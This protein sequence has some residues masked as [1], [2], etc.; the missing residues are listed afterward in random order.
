LENLEE[1]SLH[2]LNIE[3]IEV[4]GNCCK[5]LKILYLQNNLIPRI[6]NLKKLKELQYLNLALN[7]IKL[8]EGLDSCES[9]EKLDL[10]VNFVGVEVLA[11]S[12]RNLKKNKRL[13]RLFLT[14]NPCCEF[15]G[16]RDYVVASLPWL[17][18]LDGTKISKSE[19]IVAMQEL[20]SIEKKLLSSSNHG[21]SKE[22]TDTAFTPENRVKW[23]KDEQEEEKRRK[24]E[25][26]KSVQHMKPKN[27]L[28]EARKKMS[29]KVTSVPD[30][31]LPPQRNM[32]KVKFEVEDEPENIIVT[33]HA[34]RFLDTSLIDVDIHPRWFQCMIKGKNLLL[35][36]PEEVHPSKSK[37]KRLLHNGHLKLILPK[38]SPTIGPQ[39]SSKKNKKSLDRKSGKNDTK[40][41]KGLS[42]TVDIRNI[43]KEKA[44]NEINSSEL[45][46]LSRQR[47]KEDT[48]AKDEE[49]PDDFEDDD[50]VPPLI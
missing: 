7:N 2:Q 46:F 34:P 22:T 12:M 13:R 31:K 47:I 1:L 18:V 8:I 27:P 20:E 39:N 41:T 42:G 29:E 25:E 9:L 44:T 24:L 37:V 45:G 30:G 21:E 35:H 3:R 19:R 50:E 48:S 6:E 49:V 36:T 15:K 40:K 28:K 26:E 32:P 23:F 33:I 10:T 38:V 14:G 16:Y 11:E 43:V 5:R 4:V 17:E